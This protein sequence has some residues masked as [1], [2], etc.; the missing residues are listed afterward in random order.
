MIMLLPLALVIA[1][2]AALLMPGPGTELFQSGIAP[3]LVALI[4]LV[5]GYQTDLKHRPTGKALGTAVGLMTVIN[6]CIG[7]VLGMVAA[8]LFGLEAGL[9][10][11]LIV[12]S[13][14]PPTLSSG[15]ILTMIAGGDGLWA[16]L[17]TV[18]LNI[19]GIISIPLILPLV[20]S[21]SGGV[22]IESWPLFEKLVFVVLIPF[23]SGQ[24]LQKIL[25][26]GHLSSVLKHI[27]TFCIT[28]TVWMIMSSTA[29]GFEANVEIPVL[30]LIYVGVG[31]FLVHTILFGLCYGGAKALRLPDRAV[32]AFVFTG[33]QKTLPVA[34][35]IL[36]VLPMGTGNAV[37]ACI[38]FHFIQLFLDSWIAS[39]WG[40]AKIQ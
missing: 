21:V 9:A 2:S 29:N 13:T 11:G 22:S 36:A 19:L 37:L 32:S 4:F 28:L 35:S 12:M 24:I 3:W 6:L 8:Q 17:F 7:P 5:N 26:A 40:K 23:L 34:I 38:L 31:S 15:I 16:L 30:P 39:H 18:A 33:S 14:V 10:L 25:G 20:S 27:P 1:I